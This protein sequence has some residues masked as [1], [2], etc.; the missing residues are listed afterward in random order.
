M[1]LPSSGPLPIRPRRRSHVVE[2][3]RA[4]FFAGLLV[5]GPAGLTLYLAWLFVDFIDS[6]VAMLLPNA[7]NPSTYLPV[8]VPGL[9]LI[10]VVLGLI[11]VGWMAA[12]YVGRRLLRI[13]DRI[14]ARMP[15]IRGLYGAMKQ[16]FETVLSKQSNTF[17]EV[18]L[19]EWPRRGAWAVAFITGR[20]EGEIRD[21]T[22]EDMVNVYVP[23]TPNPTSGY[24]LHVP[25]RDT[26]LLSMTVEEGIKFVISGGIV[27]PPS[28]RPARQPEPAI[29]PPA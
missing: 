17:R 5:T 15:V 18:V 14:L 21:L 4:Y 3:L 28:R 8:H 12:G 26:V 1:P 7:W 16:I 6:R 19:V 25:R 13:G 9:G 23:T 24:L 20:T 27:A 2:R 22:E 10:V 29:E 11:L